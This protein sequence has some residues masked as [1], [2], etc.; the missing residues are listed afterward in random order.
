MVSMTSAASTLFRAM[1]VE[2]LR[3]TV[4][5]GSSSVSSMIASVAVPLVAPAAMTIS[6]ALALTA[7]GDENVKSSPATAVPSVTPSHTRSPPSGTV[8]P[9]SRTVA[10]ARP[11]SATGF[12]DTARLSAESSSSAIVTV[13]EFGLPAVTDA[14]SA[15]SATVNV[16]SS[17]SASSAVVTVTVP[18]PVVAPA[19]IVMLVSVP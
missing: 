12:G 15:A 7:G 17:S 19:A 10:V 8:T 16:S 2:A 9:D 11:P 4:S 14:G 6:V 13:T 1:S 3:T 18:V 5:S